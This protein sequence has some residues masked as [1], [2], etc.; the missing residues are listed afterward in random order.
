MKIIKHSWVKVGFL[1]WKCRKCSC[2]KRK[3]L[4]NPAFKKTPYQY[5]YSRNDKQFPG[6]PECKSIIHSDK[7]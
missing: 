5:F 1:I 7:I 2:I 3:I 4:N 6:L